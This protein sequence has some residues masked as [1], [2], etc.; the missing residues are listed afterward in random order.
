[1]RAASGAGA[2]RSRDLRG[3]PARGHRGAASATHRQERTGSTGT[4]PGG[5]VRR[6]MTRPKIISVRGLTGPRTRSFQD[7]FELASLLLHL[8]AENS[9]EEAGHE[10]G[11]RMRVSAQ[12]TPIRRPGVRRRIFNWS[13]SSS[14]PGSQGFLLRFLKARPAVCPLRIAQMPLKEPMLPVWIRLACKFADDFPRSGVPDE[15]RREP[16]I[17]RSWV[18]C[19]PP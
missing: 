17:F 15:E 10:R 11:G 12:R 1:M 4:C 16:W 18:H 3:R 19:V 13:A 8:A 9:R 2:A 7:P 14:R 6:K 5:S